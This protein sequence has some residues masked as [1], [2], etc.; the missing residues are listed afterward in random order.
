[1]GEINPDLV[2]A[3]N[4]LLNSAVENSSMTQLYD[5]VILRDLCM[6]EPPCLAEGII[7]GRVMSLAALCRMKC[8]NAED[9]PA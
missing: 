6:Q 7:G 8:K 9:V 1:V 5:R 3:G 4:V 2:L